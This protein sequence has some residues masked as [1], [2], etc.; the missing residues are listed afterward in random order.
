MHLTWLSRKS[1]PCFTSRTIISTRW[2]LQRSLGIGFSYTPIP[3]SCWDSWDFILSQRP[4]QYQ[5]GENLGCESYS[6]STRRSS[7]PELLEKTARNA[8]KRVY[9][10]LRINCRVYPH[11][12]V[13]KMVDVRRMEE[14]PSVDEAIRLNQRRIRCSAGSQSLSAP[15]S[16]L[17]RSI[18]RAPA[19][20]LSSCE[21]LYYPRMVLVLLGERPTSGV[22]RN[23]SWTL[24][25]K[26]G[27]FQSKLGLHTMNQVGHRRSYR[28]ARF[29]TVPALTYKSIK[30]RKSRAQ[31]PMDR[32]TSLNMSY[33][34]SSLDSKRISHYQTTFGL[35][36]IGEASIQRD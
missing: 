10:W 33:V 23:T 13:L 24:L 36:Q 12:V 20:P 16:R 26:E 2:S 8:S 14:S 4:Q 3:R 25:E 32:G 6:G 1:R 35:N 21:V 29:S 7:F 34:G 18:E 28:F 5:A 19:G 30:R 31:L 17:W 9:D 11:L 27:S 22:Q 15:P